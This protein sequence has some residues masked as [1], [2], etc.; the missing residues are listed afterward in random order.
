MIPKIAIIPTDT[1][2]SYE[3]YVNNE[4]LHGVTAVHIDIKV[5]EVPKVQ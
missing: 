4:K 2:G 3:V 1:A 5:N